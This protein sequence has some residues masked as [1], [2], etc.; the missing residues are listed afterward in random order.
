MSSTKW[1]WLPTWDSKDPEADR[2]A[3]RGGWELA[4][5]SIAAGKHH[6]VI[7]DEF[8]YAILFG[9]VDEAEVLDTLRHKP[10]AVHVLITGRDT[11]PALIEPANLVT[12]M[13]AVKHPLKAG[14][15][16][17]KGIEF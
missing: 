15:N 5:S 10:E 2:Q 4:K 14:I 1:T 11:S 3:A 8:T 12:E 13:R 17:Q 9:V 6:L 16:A 7:L